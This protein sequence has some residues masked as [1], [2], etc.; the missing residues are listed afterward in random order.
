M[1]FYIK[2]ESTR[3]AVTR[4]NSASRTL[5]RIVAE[6]LGCELEDNCVS[7]VERVPSASNVADLPPSFSAQ[8]LFLL[9]WG[10]AT[11]EQ[12]KRGQIWYM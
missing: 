6:F 8:V 5:T 2:N 3:C 10:L 9:G 12:L 4:G 11:L 1:A 7:R